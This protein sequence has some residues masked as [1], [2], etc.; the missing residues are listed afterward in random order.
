MKNQS[1]NESGFEAETAAK[2]APKTKPGAARKR[3]K[4]MQKIIRKKE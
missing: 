4:T 1:K 3:P 2:M